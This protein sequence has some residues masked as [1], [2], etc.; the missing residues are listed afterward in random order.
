LQRWKDETNPRDYQN[1]KDKIQIQE[2]VTP[3]ESS[4]ISIPDP[5][6]FTVTS[7]LTQS[8]E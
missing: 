3:E 1:E 4:K 6:E 5:T 8:Q 2:S 7:E